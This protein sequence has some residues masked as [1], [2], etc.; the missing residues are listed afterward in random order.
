MKIKILGI[1]PSF[2][3]FGLVLAET[4]TDNLDNFRI[5]QMHIA[6]T[7]EEKVEKIKYVNRGGKRQLARVKERPKTVRKNADDL[8][9]A[10]ILHEALEKYS[11][12]ADIAIAEVP[13][14]SQ[15]A[16]AMASYGVC[17]GVL[18]S[19]KIPLI[20]VTPTDVKLAGT[21]IAT[22][23]KHEMIESAVKAHPYA[24]WL[25][26]EVKSKAKRGESEIRFKAI[27][28]H[29]A[30]ATFAI[31]AGLPKVASFLN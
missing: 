11:K 16:R 31:K 6:Q 9:R 17:I 14:G 23:T 28:E 4:D 12:E 30:D 13:V 7:E 1:D 25:T 20:Q 29:L 27:N 18:A 8:R 15:D 21:G 22:A 24:Q 26:H 2:C 19:C 5:L 10:R 3:N